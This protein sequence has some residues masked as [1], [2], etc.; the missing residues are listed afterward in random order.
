MAGEIRTEIE[1]HRW[2]GK[3]RT[4]IEQLRSKEE[5]RDARHDEARGGASVLQQVRDHQL[6]PPCRSDSKSDG[7]PQN[8]INSLKRHFRLKYYNGAWNIP[9]RVGGYPAVA[10][11][12][13]LVAGNICH[14]AV[15]RP[16]SHNVL[17]SH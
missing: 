12:V 4:E 15:A 14:V 10:L 11:P 6:R 5:R 9:G 8:F 2:T 7:N 1:Q 13:Q 16:A 3:R 17:A